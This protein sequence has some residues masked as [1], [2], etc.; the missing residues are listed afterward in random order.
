MTKRKICNLCVLLFLGGVLLPTLWIAQKQIKELLY[1]LPCRTW[2]DEIG[3]FPDTSG[4]VGDTI[5]CRGEFYEEMIIIPENY[6]NHRPR[7]WYV[8]A[9]RGKDS[10]NGS[11]DKPF[12]TI[13]KAHEMSGKPSVYTSY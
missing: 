13:T 11:I 8:D 6:I 2:A 12:K 1:P 4:Y 7:G 5:Y 10:N 9:N 3:W